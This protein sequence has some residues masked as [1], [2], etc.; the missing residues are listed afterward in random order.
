MKTKLLLLVLL[1]FY[2]C[3]L[4]SQVP[5]GFNYQAIATDAGHP[6]TTPIGVR[7]SIQSDSINPVTTFWVEEYSSIT[8]NESGLF[9]LVVGKGTRKSGLAASFGDIDWSVTPKFLMTEI[10][11]GGW[12]TMGTSRLWSVPYSMMAGALSGTIDSL[13]IAS[14]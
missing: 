5:Q 12:K 7:I 14:K 2:F 6:I 11:Y 1:S 10:N 9:T 8:P 3:L 13:E 4:S